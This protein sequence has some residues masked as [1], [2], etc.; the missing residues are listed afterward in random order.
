MI[1]VYSVTDLSEVCDNYLSVFILWLD[2]LLE[3][4]VTDPDNLRDSFCSHR[5]RLWDIE[6]YPKL[7]YHVCRS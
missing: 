7:S 1:D 2:H 4:L 6:K 5:K 3:M